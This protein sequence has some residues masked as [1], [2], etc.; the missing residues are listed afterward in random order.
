VLLTANADNVGSIRIIERNGG[1]F[2]GEGVS[3]QTLKPIRRY[4]IG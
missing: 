1:V 2:A 4:W 3:A